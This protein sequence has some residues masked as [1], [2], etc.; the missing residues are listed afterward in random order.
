AVRDRDEVAL[1]DLERV[2][3]LVVE[4]LVVALRFEEPE[5][6]VVPRGAVEAEEL[7][8]VREDELAGEGLRAQELAEVL[9][10]IP[11]AVEL[12]D[13]AAAV[14]VRDAVERGAE[15][16]RAR[17]VVAGPVGGE[18]LL[19]RAP[20]DRAPDEAAGDPRSEACVED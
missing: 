17:E 16:E 15:D 13:E 6:E 12:V 18:D 8:E 4:G 3:R 10:E 1:G 7:T 9:F 14:E 19:V 11:A 2:E 20:V 5:V